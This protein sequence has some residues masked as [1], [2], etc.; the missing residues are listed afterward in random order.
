M[1]RNIARKRQKLALNSPSSREGKV[2]IVC[3]ADIDKYM[4][5]AGIIPPFGGVSPDT[6]DNVA[7]SIWEA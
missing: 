5:S 3:V 6:I 1:G 7:A 4:S 2:I